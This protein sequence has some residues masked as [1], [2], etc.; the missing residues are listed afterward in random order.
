MHNGVYYHS[1]TVD[2]AVS[3]YFSINIFSS[4]PEGGAQVLLMW[5]QT[6]IISERHH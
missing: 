6:E 4:H 2:F 1:D 3:L 5:L